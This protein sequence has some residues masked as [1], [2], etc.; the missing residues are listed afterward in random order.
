M[1]EDVDTGYQQ[2]FCTVNELV[3]WVLAR[4]DVGGLG[5]DRERHVVEREGEAPSQRRFEEPLEIGALR[6]VAPIAHGELVERRHVG[7]APLRENALEPTCG[8]QRL[9]KAVDHEH[10]RVELR[11]PRELRRE[12]GL[13]GGTVLR[14]QRAQGG[15]QRRG[16]PPG[17]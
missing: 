15:E 12:R 10:R 2:S 11:G 7:R 16:V 13:F 6:K 3:D 17:E 14:R 4:A 1:A 8:I 9:R 5:V